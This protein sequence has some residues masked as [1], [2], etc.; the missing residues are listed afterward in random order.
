MAVTAPAGVGTVTLRYADPWVIGA[1]WIGVATWI[2]LGLGWVIA[3]R[4]ERRTSA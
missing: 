4:R 3:M 1:L 2:L